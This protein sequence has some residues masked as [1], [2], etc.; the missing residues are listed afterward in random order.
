MRPSAGCLSVTV[1]YCMGINSIATI[2]FPTTIVCVGCRDPVRNT[3]RT[4]CSPTAIDDV[5]SSN[6]MASGAPGNCS[7]G[8]LDR[9]AQD[10]MVIRGRAACFAKTVTDV[11]RLNSVT[12]DAPTAATLDC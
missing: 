10:S 4:E 12:I 3:F 8:I 2:R 5:G 11:A 1:A 6:A 9:R 7:N